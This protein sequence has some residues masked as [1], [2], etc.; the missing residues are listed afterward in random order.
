MP[1]YGASIFT[2]GI[3]NLMAFFLF[4]IKE[5]SCVLL[6]SGIC[7]WFGTTFVRSTLDERTSNHYKKGWINRLN[8]FHSVC[9]F[10]CLIA[11]SLGCMQK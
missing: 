2:V 4:G 9:G 11:G 3:L 1:L 5:S 7:F 6:A 10:A 8:L